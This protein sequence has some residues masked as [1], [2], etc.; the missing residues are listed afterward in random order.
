MIRPDRS[1]ADRTAAQ[2][3]LLLRLVWVGIVFNGAADRLRRPHA[4]ARTGQ[5]PLCAAHR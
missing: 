5:R 2:R 3:H 4:D 1:L